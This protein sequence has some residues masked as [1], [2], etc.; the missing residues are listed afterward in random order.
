MVMDFAIWWSLQLLIARG[1]SIPRIMGQYI[2]SRPLEP[3]YSEL[4]VCE[5]E[6]TPAA[7]CLPD[8]F[9]NS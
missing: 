1:A 9:Y 7:A 2:P 6:I 5:N 4:G 3:E 8:S